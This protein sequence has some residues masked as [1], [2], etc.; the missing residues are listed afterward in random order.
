[1]APCPCAPSAAWCDVGWTAGSAGT[2]AAV[3]G[4]AGSNFNMSSKTLIP[5]D[6]KQMKNSRWSHKGAE[7]HL[8]SIVFL[9]TSTNQLHGDFV[10][11]VCFFLFC[12]MVGYSLISV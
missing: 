11:P 10:S 4:A 3:E 1:M 2:W 5:G 9:Q 7:L 6:N 8:F 12:S